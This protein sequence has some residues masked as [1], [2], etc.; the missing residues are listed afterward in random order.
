M[1]TRRLEWTLLAAML[2]VVLGTADL[3]SQSAVVTPPLS[4]HNDGSWTPTVVRKPPDGPEAT[5]GCGAVYHGGR[6]FMG[7]CSGEEGFGNGFE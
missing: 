2:L 6:V 3:R 4:I 7:A 1:K 5:R